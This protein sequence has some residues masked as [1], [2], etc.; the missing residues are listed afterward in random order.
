M[1][2]TED[3]IRQLQASATPVRPRASPARLTLAWFGWVTPF[4]A[5]V[6]LAIS[7]RPD[8]GGVWL[9]PAFLAGSAL[10]LVVA[11]C[12]AVAAF[13]TTVPGFDRWKRALLM[14]LPLAWLAWFAVTAAVAGTAAPG[15]LRDWQCLPVL[16]VF[17]SIP[18]VVI[19]LLLRHG[20]PPAPVRT[21]ALGGLASGALADLGARLCHSATGQAHALWHAVGVLCV[22]T[23]AGAAGGAVLRWRH[24]D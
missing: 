11:G 9:E 2:T 13:A 23:I 20:A 15:E 7:P 10:A 21:L 8:L 17:A 19:A 12:A 14:G 1:P 5:L 24:T 6:V 4:L 22:M 3:L 18:V 16:L